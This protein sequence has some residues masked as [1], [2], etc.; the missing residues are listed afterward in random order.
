[1]ETERYR[2]RAVGRILF[3]TLLIILGLLVVYQLIAIKSGEGLGI[4]FLG[5]VALWATTRRQEG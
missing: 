5:I 4:A 3:R 1:M 2:Q